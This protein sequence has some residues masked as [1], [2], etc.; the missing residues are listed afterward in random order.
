MI[1]TYND[2]LACPRCGGGIAPGPRC[3]PC[4]ITYPVLEDVPAL[5]ADP[6]AKLWEWRG[7]AALAFADMERDEERHRAAAAGAL[8]TLTRQRLRR[9]LDAKVLFRES[10]QGVLEP[11]M[12]AR[13][14]TVD[15][16]RLLLGKQAASQTLL[17][18]VANVYRDWGWAHT[19]EN[20]VSADLVR[21]AIPGS[22]KSLL[23]LGAGACRLPYDLHAL[24]GAERTIVTDINP[25]YL[26]LATKV[27]GGSSL[28]LPEFPLAPDG[29]EN[30][31]VVRT[32]TAPAPVGPGLH[33]VLADAMDPPFAA[34]AFDAVL[35]PWFLDIVP[36]DARLLAP[37]INR[38]LKPGGTWAYFGSTVFQRAEPERCYSR[39]ELLGVVA[40]SGFD[41][42]HQTVTAVDYLASPASCQARREKVL[43]FG[44]TKVSEARAAA[45]FHVLPDWL[46][47][48]TRKVPVVPAFGDY[49]KSQMMFAAIV[50]L[51][52]GTRSVDEI[53]A[54]VGEALKTP[55]EQARPMVVRFLAQLVE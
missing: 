50:Q 5:F 15:A 24:L 43:T 48:T 25:F 55:K 18:Y 44:A 54:F 49:V 39:E 14:A 37:K 19:D 22:P 30:A 33:A 53:A 7:L 31:A 3:V 13:V 9:V 47:D 26:L 12:T 35:T 2:L 32:L 34:G 46:T 20:R 8:D 36:Q 45:R 52:D 17:G 10:V 40:A 38:L 29:L 16:M 11:L 1:E 51:A 28:R 23:V 6:E 41:V 21:A 27:M 4:G 42:A